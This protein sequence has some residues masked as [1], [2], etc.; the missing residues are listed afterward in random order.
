MKGTKM[1]YPA[2]GQLK[3]LVNEVE[4][5]LEEYT[6]DDL[7]REVISEM[8]FDKQWV[9]DFGQEAIHFIIGCLAREVRAQNRKLIQEPPASTT[10]S[11]RF[12][13]WK[14]K[15]PVSKKVSELRL[16]SRKDLFAIAEQYENKGAH[17]LRV[18]AFHRNLGSLCP[19]GKTLQDVLSESEMEMVYEG[20]MPKRFKTKKRELMPV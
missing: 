2:I 3:S 15:S 7:I 1:Q 13:S 18:A 20:K 8:N 6:T 19:E 9:K 14:E 12:S 4:S 10:A 11:K 16:M 5:G 17:Y